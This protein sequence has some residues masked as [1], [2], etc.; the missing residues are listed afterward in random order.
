MT[1]FEQATGEQRQQIHLKE[2]NSAEALKGLMD[3]LG[4]QKRTKKE[5]EKYKTKQRKLQADWDVENERR[6]MEEAKKMKQKKDEIAARVL[7]MMEEN[8]KKQ[9]AENLE[10]KV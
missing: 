2:Y 4:F 6:V 5:Y 3:K 10:V 1:L 9:Q 8:L 7:K